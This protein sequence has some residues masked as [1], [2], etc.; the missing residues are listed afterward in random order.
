[1]QTALQFLVIL[2]LVSGTGSFAPSIS[3][4]LSFPS[5]ETFASTAS[6]AH[7]S[8]QRFKPTC[9]GTRTA[10]FCSPTMTP[11][12]VGIVGGGITGYALT[13]SLL[14]TSSTAPKGPPLEVTIFESSPDRAATGGGI[15]IN[16]GLVA[17]KSVLTDE[18]F[19]SL[20]DICVEMRGVESYTSHGSNLQS[21]NNLQRILTLNVTESIIRKA[22]SL[23]LSLDPPFAS[24]VTVLRSSLL[25]FLQRE[26][27]C[28]ESHTLTK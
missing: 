5:I 3:S 10:L 6:H 18:S 22:P 15:Q 20:K 12:R 27:R 9:R 4:T 11:Y 13:L 2:A 19:S 7:T 26:V 25:S 24:S 21:E 14:S 17:L 23:L 1:M 16:G 8:C 28:G